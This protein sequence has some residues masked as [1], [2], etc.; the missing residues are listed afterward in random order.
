M[1]H[2][3]DWFLMAAL[4]ATSAGEASEPH[5][6]HSNPGTWWTE[7]SAKSVV[8]SRLNCLEIVVHFLDSREAQWRLTM[9]LMV[10]DS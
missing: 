3:N 6:P 4:S 7:D 1:V 10:V 5:L 9:L 8:K 2:R